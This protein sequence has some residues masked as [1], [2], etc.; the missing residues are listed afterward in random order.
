VLSG[1]A[2][3]RRRVRA[4]DALVK[5][6][7]GPGHMHEFGDVRDERDA[8][9]DRGVGVDGTTDGRLFSAI[10]KTGGGTVEHHTAGATEPCDELLRRRRLPRRRHH[11]NYAGINTATRSTAA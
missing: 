1:R 5:T 11:R 6:E 10:T 8:K 4:K 9:A 7:Y 2:F 3:G